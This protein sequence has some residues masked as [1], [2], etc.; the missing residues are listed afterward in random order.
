MFISEDTVETASYLY[1]KI[2]YNI[3]YDTY[4]SPRFKD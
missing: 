2:V 1:V 4:E 3:V